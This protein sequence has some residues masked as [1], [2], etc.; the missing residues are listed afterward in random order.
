MFKFMIER[1]S[2][3]QDVIVY[4]LQKSKENTNMKQN[5][6]SQNSLELKGIYSSTF[7]SDFLKPFPS[8]Q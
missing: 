1:M 4:H 3:K 6:T 7:L 8:V 2:W 5:C